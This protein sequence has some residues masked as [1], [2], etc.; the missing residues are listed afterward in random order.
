M[1]A[2][3]RILQTVLPVFGI[4]AAGFVYGRF[5]P[6]P[7][8]EITELLV[9][10]MLPCL[11][12]G[13]LGSQD[14]EAFEL[15]TIGAG[16]GIVLLGTGVIAGLLFWRRPERNALLLPSLFMNTANMAFPIALFAF[17]D[18]GLSR[19]V[20]FYVA[21]NLVHVSVGVNLAHAKGSWK[22]AFRTPMVYAAALAIALALLG[23]HLPGAVSRPLN[24]VGEAT[25][26]LMLLLLGERLGSARLAY[27]KLALAVTGVRLVGGLLVG[28]FAV[29]ALGLSGYVRTAILIGATMPA[30]VLNYVLG[31]R[32]QLYPELI[33]TCVAVTTLVSVATTPLCL[34]IIGVPS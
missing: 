20:V 28:L 9:W 15:L 16:A 8:R 10:I 17:G 24:L 33:A 4:I 21:V 29:W 30:A 11:V 23:I 13:S 34:L 14:L 7:A 19:Q 1:D 26:P 25:I 27:L 6:L 3:A 31:E 32:Y 18:A 22:E 2:L 5:R 12:V